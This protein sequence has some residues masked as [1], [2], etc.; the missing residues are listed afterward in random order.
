MDGHGWK[1]HWKDP[2]WQ[3]LKNVWPT[4][5]ISTVTTDNYSYCTEKQNYRGQKHFEISS[6]SNLDKMISQKC[7][8]YVIH[9]HS[10]CSFLLESIGFR[11]Y[12]HYR[13]RAFLLLKKNATQHNNLF[14][15]HTHQWCV[16]RIKLSLPVP[17]FIH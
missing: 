10:L 12:K 16:S 15:T 1:V 11:I 17:L 9:S 14:L 3:M 8:F 5:V 7:C 2:C 13:Q 4:V 6:K